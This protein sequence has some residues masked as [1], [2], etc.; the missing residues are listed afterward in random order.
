VLSRLPFAFCELSMCFVFISRFALGPT[1][2]K[3]S[4][5]K[6]YHQDRVTSEVVVEVEAL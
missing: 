6:V 5:I 1:P 4:G 3:I 2:P